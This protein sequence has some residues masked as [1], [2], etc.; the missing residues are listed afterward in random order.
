MTEDTLLFCRLP[1]RDRHSLM[2]HMTLLPDT[3]ILSVVPPELKDDPEYNRTAVCRCTERCYCDPPRYR[4][5]THFLVRKGP[6][7]T[8]L[9]VLREKRDHAW[10]GMDQFSTMWSWMVPGVE[11]WR[12]LGNGIYE[13][14]HVRRSWLSTGQLMI[15]TGCGRFEWNDELQRLWPRKDIISSPT[16]R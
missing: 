2:E 3:D 4:Q 16:F 5:A 10:M 6:G 15:S 11:L 13:W 7:D 8:Q 1:R 14:T 9:G 12:P